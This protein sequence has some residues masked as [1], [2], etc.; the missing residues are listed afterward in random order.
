[1]GILA[2]VVTIAGAALLIL[3]VR[4]RAAQRTALSGGAAAPAYGPL[5]GKSQQLDWTEGRVMVP[6]AGPWSADAAAWPRPV[7]VD[8]ARPERRYGLYGSMSVGRSRGNT[9]VLEHAAVSRRHARLDVEGGECWILDSGST[10]GTFVNGRRVRG[11]QR[12]QH[13]D[14][15]RFAE[16]EFLFADRG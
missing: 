14:V 8:R 9:I 4:A 13:G 3:L 2:L 10:N 15:V 7:L 1:L 6:L 11:P 16:V 12:L 5:P